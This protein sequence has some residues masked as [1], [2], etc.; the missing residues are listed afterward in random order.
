MSPAGA[1]FCD[2]FILQEAHENGIWLTKHLQHWTNKKQPTTK[3]MYRDACLQKKPTNISRTAFLTISSILK[4]KSSPSSLTQNW[5]LIFSKRWEGLNSSSRRNQNE[6]SREVLSI[7]GL[8]LADT[9]SAIFMLE[10]RTVV[11]CED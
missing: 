4:T 1:S 5:T 6:L 11:V 8:C 10:G 3:T 7:C 2:A 9:C